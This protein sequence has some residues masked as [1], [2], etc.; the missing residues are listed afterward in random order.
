[1]SPSKN[2][3]KVRELARQLGLD[4][5]GDCVKRLRDFAL[6]KVRNIIDVLPVDSTA[7]LLQVAAG[8]V[9][10][11]VLFIHSDD[12][13]RRY[14]AEY[15]D[16]WPELG[17]QLRHEFINRDTLGLVLAH[18]APKQEAHR[19]VAFI[20]ARGDRSVRAYFTA[21]HEIAH[22]L[23]Q[24][25]Q[26]VFS[27]FRRVSEDLT[28]TKDPIEAL[29]DQVAGELAFYEPIVRPELERELGATGRL[30]LDG[31]SRVASIV[32]PEASFSSA[33]HGLVRLSDDPLAF[34]VADM[35][36]KPTEARSLRSP[37]LTFID[38]PLPKEKLRVVTVFPNDRASAAGFKIF[39]H[40]RVPP[41]SVI[42]QVYNE[43]RVGSVGAYE[44]QATWESGGRHLPSLPLHVEARMFGSVVYA[45]LHCGPERPTG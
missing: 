29:V 1:M 25:P 26:L 34:L 32:A 2:N 12:D 19:N 20:D 22:L 8:L 17:G 37:Q 31:I 13:I 24:P 14:G 18:P 27:G 40:M 43:N 10:V 4:T 30:T 44:D 28:S 9:S 11:K 39:Q 15:K 3:P 36:L 5:R 45:L 33:A 23:L 7:T 38:D 42:A 41:E 6:S 21:W 16:E 35:Q